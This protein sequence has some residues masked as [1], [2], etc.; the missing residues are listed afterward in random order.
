[1]RNKFALGLC[2]MAL[3]LLPVES[4]RSFQASPTKP[5]NVGMVAL[6]ADP[7]KYEGKVVQ[8]IGFLCVEY[9]GDALYLHKEDY[10]YIDDKNAFSL[11]LSD[12]QRKQFKAM[13]LKYVIIEGTVYANGPERWDYAGAI[14]NIRRLDIWRSRPDIPVPPAEAPSRC[15]R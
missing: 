9:E 1:V 13:S 7:Q 5:L 12:A 6:L 11:R 15:S 4:A 14:G 2:S 8:T 10:E 3:L